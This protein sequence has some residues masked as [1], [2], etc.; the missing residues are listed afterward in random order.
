MIPVL[1]VLVAAEGLFVVVENHT[2]NSTN[3]P[4]KRFVYP[5][6]YTNSSD[7]N[8]P[9]AIYHPPCGRF[10]SHPRR[11]CIGSFAELQDAVRYIAPLNRDSAQQDAEVL[12]DAALAFSVVAPG[13]L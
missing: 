4:F 10:G 7:N 2:M 13:V 11:F 8:T 1:T 9:F 6:E 12:G 5:N 3:Q